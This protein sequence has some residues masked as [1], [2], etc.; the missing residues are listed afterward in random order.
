VPFSPVLAFHI[1]AGTLGLLSGTAA[2]SFRKGSRRHRVTGSVFVVAMLSLAAS[3]A[4]LGFIKH[5]VLNGMMGVL[6]LY[7]VATAWWTARRRD[8]E[9]GI[10]DLAALIVPLGVGA[11]LASYGL[12][13]AKSKTGSMGGFPAQAY[14]VFGSVAL[15]FAAGDVRMLVRGGVSGRR[16]IAR[17]LWRMCFALFISTGSLFLGQQQVFPASWRNTNVLLLLGIL[18][19]ILMIFWRVRLSFTRVYEKMAQS[20]RDEAY[21]LRT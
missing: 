3:G 7:L 12:E 6:T 15:L 9:V 8:G 4:Y 17:H 13:A 19:L 14:F 11:G 20:R 21:S 1:C 5:Q 10:F 18:P 16:R 2:M